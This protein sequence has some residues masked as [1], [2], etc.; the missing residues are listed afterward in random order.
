MVKSGKYDKEN[1][2]IVIAR[3]NTCIRCAIVQFFSESIL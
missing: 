1:N 2:G 3:I